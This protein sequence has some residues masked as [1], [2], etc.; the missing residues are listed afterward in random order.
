MSSHINE[1]Y[2]RLLTPLSRAE[3]LLECHH[4]PISEADQLDD[5]DFISRIMHV[6]EEIEEAVSLN[7]VQPLIDENR[8]SC[9]IFLVCTFVKLWAKRVLAE[10]Q[11]TVDELEALVGQ[12]KWEGVKVAAVRLRYLEG[13][14]K[15][16][17][18]WM[19]NH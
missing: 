15:A 4:L 8:G 18:K 13:I 3:Y 10:M 16:A 5:I 19:E 9:L 12:E 2:Q 11:N 7:E 1:A 6:R 14:D 17:R